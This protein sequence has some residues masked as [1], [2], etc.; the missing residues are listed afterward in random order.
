L[1]SLKLKKYAIIMP[2]EGNV[3]IKWE[4]GFRLYMIM[5]SNLITVGFGV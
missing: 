4:N 3:Y 1:I 5:T 2:V